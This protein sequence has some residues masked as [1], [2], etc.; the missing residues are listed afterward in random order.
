[1]KKLI[2]T[3]TEETKEP[4]LFYRFT[5]SLFPLFA[6]LFVAFLSYVLFNPILTTLILIPLGFLWFASTL[7]VVYVYDDFLYIVYR[8]FKKTEKGLCRK[9]LFKD[10]QE[11]RK[12]DMGGTFVLV[13]RE[14]EVIEDITIIN[15]AY[16][17]L[18]VD[19]SSLA[20]FLNFM[21]EKGVHIT[22]KHNKESQAE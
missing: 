4:K 13:V 20:E 6:F 21:E 12:Y 10:I 18:D 1:M 14:K 16:L 17:W 22:T 11:I 2:I 7:R 15:R 5:M 8:I 3:I 9:I 19:P